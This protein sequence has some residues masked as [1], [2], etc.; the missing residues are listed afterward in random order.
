[1]KA[2]H[3]LLIP[4]LGYHGCDA[5]VA[6]RVLSGREGLQPS[7]NGYDWLGPGIYFWIGSPERALDWACEQRRRGKLGT[8]AVVGALIHN[9]SEILSRATWPQLSNS[10]YQTD[11]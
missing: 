2:E 9:L 1:M 11:S 7:D 4:I 3:R 8:P 10:A 6:P 5:T